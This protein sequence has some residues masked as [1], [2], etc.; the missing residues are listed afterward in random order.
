MLKTDEL[1][2]QSIIIRLMQKATVIFAGKMIQSAVTT[3]FIL[4]IQIL[5]RN[6]QYNE[7]IICL[8]FKGSTRCFYL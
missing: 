3:N 8:H 5:I 2:I 1:D 6:A 7:R 4:G